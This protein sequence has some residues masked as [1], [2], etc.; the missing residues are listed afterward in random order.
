MNINLVNFIKRGGEMAEIIKATSVGK[1]YIC[2]INFSGMPWFK[3]IPRRIRFIKVLKSP[4]FGI[5]LAL[6]GKAT[7]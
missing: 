3:Q 6:T 4:F 2:I 7:L 1:W 5:K